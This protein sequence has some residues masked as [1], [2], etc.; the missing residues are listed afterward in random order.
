MTTLYPLLLNPALH[1]KV[2]GGRKLETLLHKALPTGEPYGESWEL[3]DTATVANGVLAGQTLGALLQQWGHDLI[4]P[5]NDPTEGFPLL[6]KFLDAQDWLSVQVHPND[7]Q[8]RALEGDPRGKTEAWYVLAVDPGSTL[9]K[10]IQ[11]GTS[12]TAMADAIRANHLEPLLVYQAVEP[13]D[14]LLNNA[15]GVHALGPGIV[16]YEIQQ[17]SDVTYRLRLG[18]HGFGWKAAHAAYRERRECLQP[19]ERPRHDVYG[20]ECDASGGCGALSVLRH[21]AASTESP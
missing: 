14:V 10:G 9:V 7:E 16:I 18:A 19:D 4:G 17:S 12:Q 3:H 21:A 8:A 6:A 1:I 15:G 11:P 20:S 5:H 2:W 13:G